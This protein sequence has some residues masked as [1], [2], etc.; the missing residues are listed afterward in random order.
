M[1]ACKN[2]MVIERGRTFVSVLRLEILPIVYKPITALT[3][4]A[5]ARLTVVGHGIPDGWRC[6]VTNVKG[7]TEINAEA[8]NLSDRD[9]HEATVVDANTIELNDV[10]A[11]GFKAYVSGGVLQYNTPMPIT[12]YKARQ[13]IK[14]KVGGT[15]LF[16]L[17]TEN[18]RITIDAASYTVTRTISAA[19]TEL[20]DWKTGVSD[21]EMVSPDT[22]PIVTAPL[23]DIKVSVVNEVTT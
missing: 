19:D 10:N 13:D 9:Y 16:S 15:V 20:L 4:T 5:P 1:A 14:N 21:L 2:E 23:R 18:G 17:T 7:M 6:A 3:Q 11:A 12:G 22:E 8:N